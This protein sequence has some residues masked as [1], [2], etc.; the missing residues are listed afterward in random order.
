M[1]GSQTSRSRACPSTDLLQRVAEGVGSS[2]EEAIVAEHLNDCQTCRRDYDRFFGSPDELAA[3]RTTYREASRPRRGG[4]EARCLACLPTWQVRGDRVELTGGLSFALPRD[5]RYLAR[6]GKYDVVSILGRGGMGYVLKGFAE[7]AQRHVA[8]KVMRPSLASDEAA[9]ARFLQ[10]ARVAARLEH[11]NV[12]RIYDVDAEGDPAFLVME[13]V[14]GSSLSWLIAAEGPLEP[15]RSAKILVDVLRALEYAHQGGIIH[16]DVKPSNVLLDAGM[17]VAKLADFG[18]ARAVCE[19]VREPGEDTLA[20]TPWYMSPEQAAASPEL[21]ARSDLF[22]AGVVL[23]EMLT[24][25]LPFPGDDRQRVM[26][27]ICA[28]TAPDPRE[29]DPSIPPRLA[30]AVDRALRK[31]PAERYQSAAEFIQAVNRYLGT[32]GPATGDVPTEVWEGRPGSTELAAS[33]AAAGHD[34]RPAGTTDRITCQYETCGLLARP[35][36]VFLCRRCNKR[37]CQRH[38]DDDLLA[39][40]EG[41]AEKVRAAEEGSFVKKSQQFS[42]P[43]E[44]QETIAALVEVTQSRSSF[45]GRLW[46]EPAVSGATRDI[47]T[48]A[49]HTR[50]SFR[51]GERLTLNVEVET[52]CYLT[53][54]DVGTSGRVSLLLEN[55]PVQAGGAC[56]AVGT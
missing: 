33:G 49:R 42:I 16:R 21:D 52:D 5:E 31:H 32:V 6:L 55:H 29:L 24:Q 34:S 7:D 38:R 17:K 13:Y 48:V 23:F 47:F 18:L 37:M 36:E 12:V 40:C 45:R 11:P 2:D 46:A 4:I 20:G 15:V 26:A 51:I 28:G 10:E 22:S 27:D 9:K 25:R 54:L 56:P 14:K 30:E 43:R 8:L 35:E 1:S 44:V 53:L 50:G 39:Y 41:C 19:V 3:L